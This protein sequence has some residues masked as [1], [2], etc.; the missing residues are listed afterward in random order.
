MTNL[1]NGLKLCKWSNLFKHRKWVLD[2]FSLWV[3]LNAKKFIPRNPYNSGFAPQFCL[4]SVEFA[5]DKNYFHSKE[6]QAHIC[7]K[8]IKFVKTQT[9]FLLA[10]GD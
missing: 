10:I 6:Q 3:A 8:I 7:N 2:H 5:S 4:S 1:K 9:W